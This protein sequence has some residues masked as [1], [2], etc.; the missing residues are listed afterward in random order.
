MASGR[1]LEPGPLGGLVRMCL[2]EQPALVDLD[3][4]LV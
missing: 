2:S 3:D 1:D 4:A